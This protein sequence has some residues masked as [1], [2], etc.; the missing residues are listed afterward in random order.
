VTSKGNAGHPG[1]RRACQ[2]PPYYA[3]NLTAIDYRGHEDL[4]W[5]NDFAKLY[6]RQFVDLRLVKEERLPHLNNPNTD[7]MFRLQRAL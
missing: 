3:P 6:Q 5:K 7:A 2:A 1:G 4:L